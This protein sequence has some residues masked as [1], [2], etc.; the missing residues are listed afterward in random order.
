MDRAQQWLHGRR[1]ALQHWA[2]DGPAHGTG[3]L[4]TKALA[5]LEALGSAGALSADEAAAWRAELRTAA[6]GPSDVRF[7]PKVA[8]VTR[9]SAGRLLHELLEQA[10]AEDNELGPAGQRFEGAAHLLGAAGVIDAAEWD[11]RERTLRGWPSEKEEFELERKL[12]AGGSQ[13][14][15]RGVYPGRQESPGGR[16]LLYVLVFA[17][18]VSCL[19]ERQDRELELDDWLDWRLSDDI[20]TSYMPAG[21]AGGDNEERIDF[22]E[23][24]PPEATWLELALVADPAVSFRVPL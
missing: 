24:P 20:G 5:G 17:D 10:V 14:D 4:L 13:V 8:P 11:N 15:L 21:G 23:A 3:E 9:E 18:G 19:V 6:S 7:E 1:R 22:R 12:N 16:R 2:T